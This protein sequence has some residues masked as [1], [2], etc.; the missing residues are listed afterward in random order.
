MMAHTFLLEK[1]RITFMTLLLDCTHLWPDG[2]AARAGAPR[3]A[4]ATHEPR[5]TT[6]GIKGLRLLLRRK[7]LEQGA[8]VALHGQLQG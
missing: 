8:N 2:L 3:D 5:C 7:R 1:L 4:A 6:D